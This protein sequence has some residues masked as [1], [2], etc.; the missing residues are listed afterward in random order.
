MKLYCIEI[1]AIKDNRQHI[2]PSI[3][4]LLLQEIGEYFQLTTGT[5]DF[6]IRQWTSQS[7]TQAPPPER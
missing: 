5:T 2:D 4:H 6:Y 1:F 7:I 3:E